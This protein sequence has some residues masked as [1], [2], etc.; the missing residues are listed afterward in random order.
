M[1]INR[2]SIDL[3]IDN[4][5]LLY[6]LANREIVKMGWYYENEEEKIYIILDDEMNY[7][8]LN[9]ELKCLNVFYEVVS[10]VATD[11]EVHSDFNHLI[12]RNF[13]KN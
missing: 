5:K 12:D 3:S 1:F 6:D 2:L 8:R 11:E 13:I 9:N 10:I 7:K 4:I